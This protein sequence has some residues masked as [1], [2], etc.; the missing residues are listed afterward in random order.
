MTLAQR[1]SSSP[2]SAYAGKAANR[3]N[4]WWSKALRLNEG[5]AIAWYAREY[6]M[7]KMGRGLPVESDPELLALASQKH[8]AL[9]AAKDLS[10][11][12]KLKAPS[13]IGSVTDV[14]SVTGSSYSGLSSASENAITGQLEKLVAITTSVSQ[15]VE[16]LAARVDGLEAGGGGGGGGSREA[17]PGSCFICHS[18]EHRMHNCPKLPRDI[19]AAIAKAKKKGPKD[20]DEE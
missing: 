3:Y 7:A 9:G 4:T 5:R 10:S 8:V 12:A 13:E 15:S 2:A 14:G 6:R 20:N 1:C 16:A 18:T 11:S 17:P 19:K